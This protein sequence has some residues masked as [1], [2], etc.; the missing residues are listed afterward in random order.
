VY[1]A[2]YAPGGYGLPPAKPSKRWYQR[3]WVW[4]VAAVVVLLIAF[5]ILG[6]VFGNK[7][8]LESKIKDFYQKQGT[9][10][11]DVHCPTSIDTGE[12]HRYTCTAVIEGTKTDVFINFIADG[13]FTVDRQ[14]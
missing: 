1:G 2:P 14:G 7:F 13:K 10:I 6:L 8:Q 11:S 12:G 4:V 5:V 9:S 3:W